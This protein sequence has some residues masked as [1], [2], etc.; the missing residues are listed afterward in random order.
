M[1][2]AQAHIHPRRAAAAP[3]FLGEDHHPQED[4]A[5]ERDS[6]LLRVIPKST[7]DGGDGSGEGVRGVG[8]AELRRGGGA[9]EHQR[10]AYG[11]RDGHRDGSDG[12]DGSVKAMLRQIQAEMRCCRAVT[13]TTDTNTNMNTNTNTN[14]TD[15][16]NTTTLVRVL[17][18]IPVLGVVLVCACYCTSARVPR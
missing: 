15:T 11:A 18:L 5:H 14:T 7:Q 12:D 9:A 13:T 1:Q 3:R 8:R 4:D 6:S 10:D 16:T 2:A 17:V